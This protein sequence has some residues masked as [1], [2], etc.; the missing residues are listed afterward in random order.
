MNILQTM[1]TAHAIVDGACD[2][3]HALEMAEFDV[4]LINMDQ[5]WEKE[6]TT[7]IFNDGSKLIVSGPSYEAV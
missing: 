4:N 2:A 7:F 6:T 5:D 1:T 3:R